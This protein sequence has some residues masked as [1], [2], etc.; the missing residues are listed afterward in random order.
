MEAQTMTYDT[1]VQFTKNTLTKE[2][3]L[4]AGWA[5]EAGADSAAYADEATVRNLTAN[6]GETLTLYAVWQPVLYRVAFDGNGADSGSME[7]QQ[8]TYDRETDVAV[9]AF[10][11]VAHPIKL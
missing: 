6:Q 7:A 5:N 3:Y 1:D 9:S 11:V 4:F 10:S 2:G 8:F